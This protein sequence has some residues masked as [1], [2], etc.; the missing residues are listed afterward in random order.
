MG[1]TDRIER[2]VREFTTSAAAATGATPQLAVQVVAY[3]VLTNHRCMRHAELGGGRGRIWNRSSEQSH[4][5]TPHG[6]LM[7][8]H[9]MLQNTRRQQNNKAAI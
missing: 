5:I 6:L 4:I 9:R 7:L 8:G 2:A 1:F 3:R